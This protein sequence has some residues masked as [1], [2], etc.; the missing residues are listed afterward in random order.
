MAEITARK[1]VPTNIPSITRP[2]RIFRSEINFRHFTPSLQS[3]RISRN[4]CSLLFSSA[5]FPVI[6]PHVMT[7]RARLFTSR[8]FIGGM[9]RSLVS[10]DDKFYNRGCYI[11]RPVDYWLLHYTA[12]RLGYIYM[13]WVR[14]RCVLDKPVMNYVP[15]FR[16][17]CRLTHTAP[18]RLSGYDEQRYTQGH[19]YD[20]YV[21]WIYRRMPTSIATHSCDVSTTSEVSYLPVSKSP[22][23]DE[24]SLQED[25]S[26]C[27]LLPYSHVLGG[28]Q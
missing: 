1:R 27:T 5:T 8:V 4:M 15:I 3:S 10:E 26:L 6:S 13:L 22:A 28:I 2:T 24:R 11:L 25:G 20:F 17:M 7:A 16:T 23:R 21:P 18:W 12:S 14:E 19:F 9:Q